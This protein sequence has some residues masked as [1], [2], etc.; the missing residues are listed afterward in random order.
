[1]EKADILFRIKLVKT[2]GEGKDDKSR[3]GLSE[4]IEGLFTHIFSQQK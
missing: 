4:D 1:M 3:Q 2:G